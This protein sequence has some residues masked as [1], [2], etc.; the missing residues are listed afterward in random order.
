M[1]LGVMAM[2]VGLHTLQNSGN[3]NVRCIDQIVI[4]EAFFA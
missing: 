1:D 3:I 2:Q 4:Y